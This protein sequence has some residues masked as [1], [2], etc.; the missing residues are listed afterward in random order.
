MTSTKGHVLL[1]DDNAQNRMLTEAQ[2]D[3]AG[4]AVTQAEGGAQAL[5]A[6]ERD[7]VD[8]VLLDVMMPGM[9][10]FETCRR[11]RALPGGEEVPILFLTALHDHETHEKALLSGADDFLGK[12][13]H[14]T[15]LLIRVRSL[16]RITRLRHELRRERDALLRVQRQKDLLTS[17]VVHDLKNP[18]A[19][20]LANGDFVLNG[21][22]VSGDPKAAVEDIM[23]SSEAMH[24]MVMNLLDISRA[25]EG[26]L[27]PELTEVDLGALVS[28]LEEQTRRR[29]ESRRQTLLIEI[30]PG[31]PK[32]HAD[33]LLLRR[34]LEN[35]LDNGM[36]YTPSGGTIA[37][38]ARPHQDGVVLE[39]RDGG[40]GVP[41][42]QRERIFDKYAQVD[43]AGVGRTS[44][45]LGL[46][47]C[48][49][50]VEVHGGGISVADNQPSGAVFRLELPRRAG[51]GA[52]TSG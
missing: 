22:D 36:R 5:A 38:A 13:I 4:Y 37:V 25:E 51:G 20:I 32:L 8:L 9:D 52:L 17:L 31:L 43:G 39:V 26:A 47:F 40:P 24:Q 11:L 6:F 49:L 50:A 33:P 10:G 46:V 29:V 14:R 44:R 2:L 41:P 30:A 35:L 18:L 3:A 1:V 28:E 23:A 45:G 19:S 21:T 42:E 7:A 48:R 12:P 15:E 34:A 27:T 16:I